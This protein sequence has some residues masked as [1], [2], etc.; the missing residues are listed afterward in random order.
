MKISVEQ[1]KEEQIKLR[2]DVVDTGIGIKA[3]DIDKLFIKFYQVDCKYNKEKKGTGL[4]LPISRQFA[5]M[6]NGD[7]NVSSQ[8][9][10]GSV[11]SLTLWQGC[12]RDEKLL[13]DE[14]RKV[15]VVLYNLH[16]YEKESHFVKTIE[17]RRRLQV[18]RQP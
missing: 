1:R 6:M 2:F 10:K 7:I 16:G 8:L 5:R 11:F 3:E 17:Y 4:G 14:S 12:K 9:D 15:S 13:R 18:H